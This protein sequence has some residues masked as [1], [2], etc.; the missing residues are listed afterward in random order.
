MVGQ[1]AIVRLEVAEFL[2]HPFV[3]GLAWGGLAGRRTL[4]RYRRERDATLEAN[5]LVITNVRSYHSLPNRVIL[6]SIVSPNIS[7][8]SRRLWPLP[9]VPV[10]A[11]SKSL[12]VYFPFFGS[13][14]PRVGPAPLWDDQLHRSFG[15]SN[16]R[17]RA[18][19]DTLSP[20]KKISILTP[21][22]SIHQPD[23]VLD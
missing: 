14:L 3:L 6:Y 11:P 23:C 8:I 7:A 9:K 10:S 12:F 16:I 1:P 22:H 20:R 2:Q 5:A 19:A 15:D 17:G 21:H 13:F 4:T 18:A